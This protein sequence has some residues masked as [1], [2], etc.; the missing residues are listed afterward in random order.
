VGAGFWPQGPLSPGTAVHVALS[1]A[2]ADAAIVSPSTGGLLRHGLELDRCAAGAVLSG[3]ESDAPGL[4]EALRLV[5]DAAL[6]LAVVNAD[7]PACL[8]LARAGAAAPLCLVTADPGHA[9]VRAHR[10]AGGCAVVQEADRG[11]VTL[12]EAGRVVARSPTAPTRWA[13][14]AVALARGLGVGAHIIESELRRPE[15]P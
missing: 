9:A 5:L 8:E 10:A 12:H 15:R 14:F 13:G 1:D 7:D 4:D 3:P 2:T 6:R 11:P